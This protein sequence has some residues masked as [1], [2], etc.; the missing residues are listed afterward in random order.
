MG[1]E[2]TWEETIKNTHNDGTVYRRVTARI[3]NDEIE[4]DL[5]VI[6]MDPGALEGLKKDIIAGTVVTD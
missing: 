1:D 3:V 2:F 4:W 5:E 6:E